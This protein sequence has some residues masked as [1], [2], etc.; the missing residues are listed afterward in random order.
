LGGKE[1]KKLEVVRRRER[2]ESDSIIRGYLFIP[3]ALTN[4]A[5]SIEGGEGGE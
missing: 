4:N 2:K 3:K 5:R 1:K